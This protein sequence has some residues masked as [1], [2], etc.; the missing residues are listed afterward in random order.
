MSEEK[1][2]SNQFKLGDIIFLNSIPHAIK[3]YVTTKV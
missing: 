2:I 1:K 3:S